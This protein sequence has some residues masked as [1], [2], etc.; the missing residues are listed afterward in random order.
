ML[1]PVAQP[2]DGLHDSEN[3][4]LD[5]GYDSRPPELAE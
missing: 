1:S 4:S 5:L 2:M 3:P